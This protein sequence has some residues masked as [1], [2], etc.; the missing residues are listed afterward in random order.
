MSLRPAQFATS[1]PSFEDAMSKTKSLCMK[2]EIWL[3]ASG[4]RTRSGRAQLR[5]Q[6]LPRFS[7]E[8][9]KSDGQILPIPTNCMELASCRASCRRV[10]RFTLRKLAAAAPST[11]S[12]ENPLL[13][14]AKHLPHV[15]QLMLAFQDG[16][17][18]MPQ[19]CKRHQAS[20]PSTPRMPRRKR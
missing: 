7:V 10:A 3:G 17:S 13:A 11:V 18:G 19:R 9:L 1:S 5:L 12:L 2:N 8:T 4:T 6:A 16:F 14:K 15:A 20:N